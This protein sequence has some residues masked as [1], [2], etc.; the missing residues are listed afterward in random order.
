M[1]T[2]AFKGAISAVLTVG[3]ISAAQVY[4]RSLQLDPDCRGPLLSRMKELVNASIISVSW[5]RPRAY[6]HN[7][8]VTLLSSEEFAGSNST[9]TIH[10]DPKD[11]T[12]LVFDTDSNGLKLCG[13]VKRLQDSGAREAILKRDYVFCPGSLESIPHEAIITN[14]R[15]RNPCADLKEF[16]WLFSEGLPA[17]RKGFS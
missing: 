11:L 10:V 4:Q 15:G 3:T 14:H 13:S 16:K 8:I 17:E 7:R 1:I 6:S 2:N 12:P 9:Q 5:S